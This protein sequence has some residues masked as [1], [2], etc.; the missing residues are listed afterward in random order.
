[1]FRKLKLLRNRNL[2]KWNQY[3]FKKSFSAVSDVPEDATVNEDTLRVVRF[4]SHMQYKP[5]KYRAGKSQHV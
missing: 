1:M 2:Y 3:W 5:Y 4:C